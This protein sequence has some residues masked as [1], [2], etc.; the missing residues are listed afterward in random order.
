MNHC[1]DKPVLLHV[2]E[3]GLS[4][5]VI[6]IKVNHPCSI[7]VQ[8]ESYFMSLKHNKSIDNSLLQSYS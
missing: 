8:S 1:R 7:E 2:I 6:I 3:K 4:L 5:A